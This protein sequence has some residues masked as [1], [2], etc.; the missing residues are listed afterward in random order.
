MS[1]I[2]GINKKKSMEEE[3]TESLSQAVNQEKGLSHRSPGRVCQQ[4]LA[5]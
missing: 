2:Y 4:A 5:K 3:H 1:C